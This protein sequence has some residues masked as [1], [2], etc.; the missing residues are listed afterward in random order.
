MTTNQLSHHSPVFGPTSPAIQRP[1]TE[2]NRHK[3][4]IDGE[5]VRDGLAQLV[6]TL[7]KLLHELLERQA[8]RRMDSGSLSDEEVERLG[9]ALMR[10][11]EEL[12]HLCDVFGF[13]D[14]DL[15]LDL[16]PLGRLL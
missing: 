7:V 8:I 4:D 16:G 5:R 3:I 14:D 11:A 13:K 6:L 1:I 12:T 15:N 2:A 10:Q 9:L